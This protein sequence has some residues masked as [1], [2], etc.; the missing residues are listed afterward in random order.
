MKKIPK[1]SLYC[2]PIFV[3]AIAYF[4]FSFDG[5]YGQDAYEYLRYTKMLKLFF[6]TGQLPGDYFWGVY[7]PIFGSLLS[8]IVPNPIVAL[9]LISTLSLSIT[10]LYI[11]KTIQLLYHSEKNAFIY[12]VLFFVLSPVVF[13]M[14]LLV[15]SDML[16]TA[17]T[18][19][20]CYHFLKYYKLENRK[21]IYFAVIFGVVAVLT[22][23]A[24]VVLVFPFAIYSLFIIT[25]RKQFSHFFS[26]LFISVILALPHFF[27]K[28]QNPTAFLN[29]TWLQEWSAMNFFKH[30]F[31]T[32]DGIENYSLPNI[33]YAFS[34]VFHP[35]YLFPGIV[36]LLFFIVKKPRVQYTF[37]FLIAY[38]LYGLFLAGIPFQNSRFLLIAFPF[39]IV[40]FYP[41]FILILETG[42][43]KKNKM[44]LLILVAIVQLSLCIYSLKTVFAL[45]LFEKQ[46]AIELKPYQNNTL[47][48][49]DV[50]IALKGRG[51]KF[52]YKN[53][54]VK[55]YDSFQ[56]N[57][58]VLFH[59][60][61][62]KEQWKD[63]NP[64]LN[65]ETL[66]T[67]SKLKKI[68]NL[69][70]GWVLYQIQ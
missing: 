26:L 50:D 4:C 30:S 69:P 37:L 41:C 22:R 2:F 59:P 33:L 56:K 66:L 45:N 38:S 61:K 23:Y 18:L 32:P 60:T 1:Y 29:H 31:D 21:N 20:S 48:S 11:H 14:G 55:K 43:I 42:I 36:F 8:F 9:Q 13:K 65:W 7:Y 62:F 70:E 16:S 49:F 39:L 35:R 6:E 54:W 44:S 53:L 27:I 25:K 12:T 46:I 28:S 3:W 19:L 52:D 15:M 17:L 57:A 34:S 51:I 47:Y 5:L 58:L 63:K 68:K 24:C 10:A 40:L 64:M 67:E